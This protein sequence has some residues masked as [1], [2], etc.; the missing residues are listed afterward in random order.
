MSYIN[1]YELLGINAASLSDIDSKSILREKKKLLQEIEL[2]DSDSIEHNGV[3][4][5]K[6][7]CIKAIDDLDNKNKKE[8]HFFIFQNKPLSDFLSKGSLI[9]FENYQIESI[10]KLPEFV[11]FISPYFSTQ[12]DKVLTDNFRKQN[13]KAVSKI[14]SVKPIT[15]ELLFEACYRGTYSIIKGFDN[16]IT[17]I[18]KKIE[19]K[20]S[21]FI[22]KQFFGLASLIK[23][24]VSTDLINLL[25][26]YFQSLRNQLAQ[27]IRKLAVDINNGPYSLYE[28]AYKIIE[29]ANEFLTDGLVKQQISK[30]YYIIKTN[31]EDEFPKQTQTSKISTS[32]SHEPVLNE[33]EPTTSQEVTTNDEPKDNSV[34]KIFVGFLIAAAGLL[35]WAFF[36]SAVQRVI[37]SIATLLYLGWIYNNVLKSENFSKQP[38]GQAVIYGLSFLVCIGGFFSPILSI[39]FVSYFLIVFLHMFYTSLTSKKFSSSQAGIAYLTLAIV[40]TSFWYNYNQAHP[41][42]NLPIVEQANSTP[43]NNEYPSSQ[44]VADTTASVIN[45]NPASE[46]YSTESEPVYTKV[47]VQNGNISD[48]LGISPKYDNSIKTKLIIS[49]ELTDVA[50][51]L[52][53]YETDRCIRFVFINDGATYTVKNIPEGKYYLK[54]AYGNDWSVKEGD[55]ICKGRFTSHAS[56]K[57]D[58]DTYDFNIKRYA[59]GNTSTPYYTLK[60]Y[61]T[62]SSEN[63][64][65]SS[66]GNSISETDFNNN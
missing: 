20:E 39:L 18:R 52:F 2:S 45:N 22:E 23:E 9:F 35:V 14:L 59:N 43:T 13:I 8:F 44:V 36:S 10:Y 5:T 19:L 66:T 48:C 51:K 16:E 28:P 38:K 46:S 62:Y 60:L 21:P 7:D 24:K 57:K 29:I 32:T 54:I 50:V 40:I 12:Y 55:P 31:Y 27:S 4:L 49:A 1:P 33:E 64:Y 37:L 61:R 65:N 34:S 58:Y 30:G 3:Q 63:S 17:D 11:D 6:A 15:N 47:L 26:S 42:I 25:P 56:F 53:D 41:K